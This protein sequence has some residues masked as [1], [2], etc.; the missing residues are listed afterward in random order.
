MFGIYRETLLVKAFSSECGA[1][2]YEKTVRE[3]VGEENPEFGFYTITRVV[4][5]EES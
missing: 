2:N 3:L 4:D 5:E 1:L